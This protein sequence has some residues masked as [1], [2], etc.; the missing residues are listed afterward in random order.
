MLFWKSVCSNHEQ[1]EKNVME[2]HLS[3]SKN[4]KYAALWELFFNEL[5]IWYVILLGQM[6]HN[7]KWKTK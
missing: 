3:N 2:F 1:L 4:M 5:Y 7:T 6:L